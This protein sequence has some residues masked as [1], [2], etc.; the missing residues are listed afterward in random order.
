MELKNKK[1]LIGLCSVL[2]IVG[3]LYYGYET[4]K[5]EIKIISNKDLV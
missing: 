4:A 5:K 1:I 2:A 3:G